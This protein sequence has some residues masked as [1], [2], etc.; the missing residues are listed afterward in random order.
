LKHPFSIIASFFCVRSYATQRGNPYNPII[1]IKPNGNL[2]QKTTLE[3]G[4]SPF[5]PPNLKFGNTAQKGLHVGKKL[6]ITKVHPQTH[7][8]LFTNLRA[9]LVIAPRQ[10]ERTPIFTSA[11]QQQAGTS[12]VGSRTNQ[13]LC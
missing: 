1:S 8:K 13:Q 12:A 10:H 4:Q 5:Y 6:C 9:A 2:A 7:L 11:T 3:C